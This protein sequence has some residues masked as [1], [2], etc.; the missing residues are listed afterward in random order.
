MKG[1]GHLLDNS[2]MTDQQIDNVLEYFHESL[3]NDNDVWC[4]LGVGTCS[5]EKRLENLRE[6]LEGIESED[7]LL[8]MYRRMERI[9]GN[10]QKERHRTTPNDR[11][12]GFFDWN[13]N[14]DV[15]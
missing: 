1:I 8:R 12:L 7:L 13:R 15:V 10:L 14:T 11:E 2:M 6:T 3:L 5:Y 9:N 4:G